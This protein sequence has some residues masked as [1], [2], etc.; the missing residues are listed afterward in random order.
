MED[1]I[2]GALAG[3]A[4]GGCS[5]WGKPNYH[6]SALAFQLLSRRNSLGHGQGPFGTDNKG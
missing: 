3:I 6:A 2:R 4:I 5:G 1:I